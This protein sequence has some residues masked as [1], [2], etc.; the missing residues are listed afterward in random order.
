MEFLHK[1]NHKKN[2]RFNLFKE[3]LNLSYS[4]NHKTII[5]TGTSRGKVKFLFF[6]KYNWKDGM[7]TPMLAEFA[8]YIDGKFFTVDIS[9]RNLENS[10]KFTMKFS[11]NANYICEDSLSFLDKFE[12]KIDLLYLDSYDGHEVENA[13]IHQLNEVKKSIKKLSQ[14]SLILLD[15]IKTKGKYSID[16]LHEEKFKTIKKTENQILLSL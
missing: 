2:T 16:Y 14:K 9:K 7:S 15:D 8:D 1:Y 5:E 6:S 10:K 12:H 4:R 11:Q 13:S 3:T